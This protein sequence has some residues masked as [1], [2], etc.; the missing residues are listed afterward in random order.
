M[1]QLLWELLNR[2]ITVEQSH[3]AADPQDLSNWHGLFE[4]TYIVC[5]HLHALSP[6]S[7]IRGSKADTRFTIPQRVEGWVDLGSAASCVQF[8]FKVMLLLWQWCEVLV[9]VLLRSHFTVLS[10]D[11]CGLG[12]GLAIVGLGFGFGLDCCGLV[13]IVLLVN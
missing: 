13:D 1:A 3:T 7:A 8:L 6:F 9:L 11:I 5:N 2:L 12:L 4:S 10:L